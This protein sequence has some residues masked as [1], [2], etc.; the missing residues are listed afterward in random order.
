MKRLTQ[1]LLVVVP[2]LAVCIACT[3]PKIGHITYAIVSSSEARL[4]GL[5]EERVDIGGLDMATYVGGPADGEAVVMLHGYSADRDVWPRFARHL[6]N[7]YRVIIPD[8]AGHGSTGFKPEWNY[9]TPAQA[10]RVVALLDRLG[11]RKAHVV[12][13]S[14]GGF[15]AAQ[16]AVAYPERTLSVALIDPAGVKSP[17]PSDMDKLLAKGRNPFEVQSRADFDTFYAMTMAQ[18]PFLPGFVLAA[19]AENYQSRRV[20]L[21]RIFTDFHHK[22]LLDDRLGEIRAP[23][24]LLWGREDR[25]LHV[26]SAAVWAAG[27]P[28]EQ[29]VLMDGIGHMPMVERPAET[30]ALYRQFLAN[31]MPQGNRS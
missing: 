2:A 16:F 29:V 1:A 11:I 4:Y 7:D 24:L 17:V 10:A 6:V 19:M 3:Y 18:P 15:T 13:N 9:S 27:L 20:E 31:L 22:Y 25:L 8:L 30:A 12:G 5:H 28:N 23:A 14:M 26:S 21:A